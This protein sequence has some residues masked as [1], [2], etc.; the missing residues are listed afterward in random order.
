MTAADDTG[1]ESIAVTVDGEPIALDMDNRG[2]Y[3]SSTPGVYEVIAKAHDIEGNEGF[4]RDVIRFHSVDNDGQYPTVENIQPAEFSEIKVPTDIMGTVD[5]ENL[6]QYSL[7]YSPKG[8]NEYT[9]FAQGTNPVIN[10]I[11]GRI[12]PTMMENGLYEIRLKAEDMWG[13]VTTAYTTYQIDGQ[14]KVGNFTVSFNDLTTP[15][16]PLRS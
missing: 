9:A 10:G 15:V 6:M 2:E 4:A 11:L 8:K 12:D 13:N 1:V 7:A 14:M 16:S 3:T 5:D